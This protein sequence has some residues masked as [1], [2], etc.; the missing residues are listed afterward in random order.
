M[1][2]AVLSQSQVMKH[3][4]MNYTYWKVIND[5]VRALTCL[6]STLAQ[7][8]T[9]TISHPVLSVPKTN[10]KAIEIFHSYIL[11]TFLKLLP[12]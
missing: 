10:N 7:L 11:T 1:A 4:G 5:R 12:F 6:T 9:S 2:I 8:T 3:F